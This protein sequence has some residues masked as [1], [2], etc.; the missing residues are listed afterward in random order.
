MEDRFN[1]LIQ[2]YLEQIASREEEEELKQLILSNQFEENIKRGIADF[3][4][5][6]EAAFKNAPYPIDADELFE[7]IINKTSPPLSQRKITRLHWIQAAAIVTLI[8]SIAIWLLFR[9]SAPIHNTEPMLTAQTVETEDSIVVV[10]QKNFIRLPDGSTVLLNS[11]SELT[12]RLPFGRKNREV[13]LKGEA[14]FEVTPNQSAPFIVRTGKIT[15]NVL[16]TAFNVNTKG[17]NVIVTVSHGLV[18]VEDDDKKISLVRPDEQIIVKPASG[19]FTKKEVSVVEEVKWKAQSLV[20]DNLTFKQVT[21]QLQN[22]FDIQFHFENPELENCRISAWFL[23]NESLSEILEMVCGTRQAQYVIKENAV[24]IS[25]GIP[26][27]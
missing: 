8:S 6:D 21:Q 7:S 17:E 3:I 14:F 4:N 24:S 15:T 1:F 16:G 23:D 12:Y 26:C 20:F 11:D 22:H 9:P 10:S 19:E 25:G 27:Q 13:S 5:Q 18:Q 2:R